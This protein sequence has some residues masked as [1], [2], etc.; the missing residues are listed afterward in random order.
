MKE[1]HLEIID[2]VSKGSR[3]EVNTLA[4]LLNISEVT[5]RKDLDYLADKGILKR[6]RGF[7]VLKDSNDINYRMAFHYKEKKKIACAAATLVEDGETI[8]IESGSTCALFAE[9]IAKHK[10]NVTIITNSVHIA[11]YVGVSTDT[12]VI[13]LGGNYQKQRQ[14]VVGP[15]TKCCVQQFSVDKIFVGTDGFS[16]E[17]GFTGDNVILVDTL[18]EMIAVANHTIVLMESE[19]FEHCGT[20]GFLPAKEVSQVIT[21][22][23]IHPTYQNILHT[24]GVNIMTV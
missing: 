7:A 18:R 11:N 12:E 24:A 3:V 16:K 6:E 23:R 4:K 1:R 14:A 15:I 13:L 22:E 2:Y 20:V 8:I 9:E 21:D 17:L 19:K 5:I 10:K